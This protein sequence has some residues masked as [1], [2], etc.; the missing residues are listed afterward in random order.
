MESDPTARISKAKI[1]GN[2]EER[3]RVLS[4]AEIKQLA[5][6]LPKALGEIQ[7]RAIW[8]MIA[9][10][11]RVGEITS[12]RWEHVD[13]ETG[14]WKLPNTK[15]GKPFAIQLSD[16]A[17]NQFKALRAKA[18]SDAKK[19]ERDVSPWV[20]PAKYKVGHVCSK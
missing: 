15:N 11:C 1:G 7:Q 20:M 4:E 16:F 10:C 18:E 2:A 8:I 13:L 17:L 6:V 12:A 9:T 3:D 14:V 5:R 19:A